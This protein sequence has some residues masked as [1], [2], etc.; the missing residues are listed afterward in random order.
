MLCIYFLL[1]NSFFVSCFFLVHFSTNINVTS[2]TFILNAFR[3]TFSEIDRMHTFPF[4]LSFYLCRYL[5]R[6]QIDAYDDTNEL[7]LKAKWILYWDTGSGLLLDFFPLAALA[8]S[9][10]A[11]KL[12]LTIIETIRADALSLSFPCFSFFFT[13]V[14]T[15]H[16]LNSLLSLV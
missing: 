13:F 16:F 15:L 5:N 8:H 12:T 3:I 4:W 1:L 11:L 14:S 9:F 2:G 6:A 10:I 7:Y